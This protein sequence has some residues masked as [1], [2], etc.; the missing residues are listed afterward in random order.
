[1]AIQPVN[2]NNLYKAMTSDLIAAVKAILLANGVKKESNLIKSIDVTPNQDGLTLLALDYYTYLSTGRRPKANKV[3][4]E[5]LIAWIKQYNVGGGNVNSLAFAIQ[6]SIYKRGI[7]GKGY[8]ESV[9]N[10]ITELTADQL[11]KALAQI[12]ADDMAI[13]FSNRK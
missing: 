6:Q 2:Y 8:S 9:T 3:P 7:K 4:I 12:I 13:A 10:N 1:M 11:A 5:S